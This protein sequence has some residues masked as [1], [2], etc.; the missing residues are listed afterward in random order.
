MS[1]RRI[2]HRARLC[3]CAIVLLLGHAAALSAPVLPTTTVR[4]GDIEFVVEVADDDTER[5]RGLMFRESMNENHG[6]LFVFEGEQPLAF[7][8]KNTRITLDILYFD[9]Q[10][11]LVSIQ[12]RVPPCVTAFCPSYPSDG[13][14]QYVLELNG[15]R[16]APLGLVR[17]AAICEAGER[18]LTPLPRCD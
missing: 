14:A 15:G 7:W 9:R 1:P 5:T 13:P 6:M 11:R 4:L 17:G 3:A 12:A 8:M 2:S 18:P 16:S 10:A